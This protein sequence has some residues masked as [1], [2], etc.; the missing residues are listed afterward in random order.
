VVDRG[1]EGVRTL[2]VSADPD[3]RFEAFAAREP[4]FAV[5]TSP[6]FLRANFTADHEREFFESGEDLVRWILWVIEQRL[7][8][9]F[10]PMTVLEY[11]C[12][13]GRL[14]IPFARRPGSVTAV[15][16]SRAMLEVA[17]H[18][19]AR[20]GVDHIELLTPPEL[21][22]SARKFDL[23][24]CVHVLQ[25][26]RPDEGLSLVSALL[27][28]VASGGIGVFHVPFATKAG[29]PVR[30]ARWTREHLPLANGLTNL[31]RGRPFADPFIPSHTYELD[32][33]LRVCDRKAIPAAH[34]V[35]EH[36]QELTNAFLFCEVPL[37]SITGVDER[38]RPLPGT[39]LRV[40]RRE[41][42]TPIA[43]RD[44]VASRSIDELNQSAEEY[45]GSLR[46]WDE[47]LAKPFSQP[48]E[49][50]P[51]LASVA[52]LLDGL[53]LTPGITV[54]EFG[55]GTG[56]LSRWLTQLGCR[57]ILLDVSPTALRMAK[58]LYERM[59]VIGDRPAPEFLEFDGRRIAL[60]DQSVDRVLT[61]DAFHHVSNP[62]VVIGE[63]GRILKPGGIA[64]FAEPGARHSLSPMSQFEMRTYAVVENDIDVHAIWRTARQAGFKDLKLAVFHSPPFYVSLDEYED[65][66]AA[67]QTT[68]RWLTSTR[69]FLRDVRSFFLFKEGVR[70]ADSRTVEGLAC[71]I[72]AR[73]TSEPVGA[74]TPIRLVVAMRNSGQATWLG[75]D[76]GYGGVELGVHLYDSGGRLRNFD[77]YRGPLTDPPREVRPGETVER[78]ITLPPLAAGDYRL[79][80]DCVAS[81]VTWFAQ[82]GSRAA[83]VPLA[84]RATSSDDVI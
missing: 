29:A 84:I 83:T 36:E 9:H 26:L 70:P 28:R 78:E 7:S 46:H 52:T 58:A 71:D 49:M 37:P 57:V 38:G 67:G 22:A 79:E 13:A 51:V 6:K 48:V 3:P 5:L 21:F 10:S 35:F 81:Q 56:W 23:V 75:A 55:A 73:L 31:L 82:I 4:Y 50:P 18:E 74:G 1:A 27:D 59:P 39:T 30:A 32:A 66:L 16:R 20:H 8:P 11:G 34:A 68:E 60:P 62:D 42:E 40:A 76:A 61:F 47:H 15:D 44:V 64:G 54:L 41:P 24:V 77:F 69:V 33:L 2:N 45:F 53:D 17:K 43:V 12:G 65:F 72:T 80:C 19:A 63:L 14:A 25:R